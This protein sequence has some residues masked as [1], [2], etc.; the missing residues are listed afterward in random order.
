MDADK[1]TTSDDEV[2]F[3][4][5]ETLQSLVSG[6]AEIVVVQTADFGEWFLVMMGAYFEAP[7]RGKRCNQVLTYNSIGPMQTNK[8][9]ST[10]SKRK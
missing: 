5:S 3:G 8:E 10:P 2:A 4:W 6:F 9:T 7:K 1:A